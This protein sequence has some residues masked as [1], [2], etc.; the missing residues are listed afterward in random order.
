MSV[1]AF[2]PGI[3]GDPD[4]DTPRLI[5]ADWLDDTDKEDNRLRADLIR[6]QCELAKL[7]AGDP[8][9]LALERREAELLWHEQGFFRQQIEAAMLM[10]G[11]SHRGFIDEVTMTPA[12]LLERLQYL[13]PPPTQLRLVGLTDDSVDALAASP[14]LSHLRSLDLMGSRLSPE[15]L[16]AL[17]ASKELSRLQHLFLSRSGLRAEHMQVLMDS[18]IAGQLLTLDVSD[19]F[20]GLVVGTACMNAIFA[21]GRFSRMQTLNIEG[22]GIMNWHFLQHADVPA[23]R[24]FFAGR[25]PVDT[26][27]LR[28]SGLMQQLTELDLHHARIDFPHFLGDHGQN[29]PLQS[30]NLAENRLDT[31]GAAMIFNAPRLASLTHLNLRMN[32]IGDTYGRQLVKKGRPSTLP[33]RSLNLGNNEIDDKDIRRLMEQPF[34][35]TLAELFLEGNVYEKFSRLLDHCSKMPQLRAFG[36]GG[37]PDSFGN[38]DLVKL[39]EALSKHS[40]A[41][42]RLSCPDDDTTVN[43]EGIRHLLSGGM[44]EHLQR[45]SIEGARL[46]HNGVRQLL[47]GTVHP[48]SSVHLRDCRLHSS[49]IDAIQDSGR[50]GYLHSLDLSWNH[51]NLAHFRG[52]EYAQLRELR[53]VG[54]RLILD[55]I[56]HLIREP[57][58]HL[59]RADLGHNFFEE[60]RIRALAEAESL[61]HVRDV[62]IREDTHDPIGYLPDA[63]HIVFRE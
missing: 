46:T 6:V 50:C 29:F 40:I 39:T 4:D 3:T 27:P 16:R 28:A 31:E 53:L 57:I 35:S 13:Q 8:R 34:R 19:N 61:N 60:E 14:H 2:L 63:P 52:S 12:M 15:G 30:L 33:L 36:I 54:C 59:E 9:R 42:L 11:R 49:A 32:R 24:R 1:E 48:L 26:V 22:N 21:S 38:D 10:E 58:P 37:E 5:F 17:L 55:D 51:L 47:Q 44:R 20:S 62:L 7:L 45:L 25:N 23:L 18:P 43:D 56:A 41:E